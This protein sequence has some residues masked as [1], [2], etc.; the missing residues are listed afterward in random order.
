MGFNDTQRLSHFWI[1]GVNLDY[2]LKLREE[3]NSGAAFG[4]DR[5]RKTGKVRIVIDKHGQSNPV[6]LPE[7]KDGTHDYGR[8]ADL[9]IAWV[10]IL[11]EKA[12][13]R[14][15]E[16]VNREIAQPLANELDA[17]GRF[18]IRASEKAS[19]PFNVELMGRF[20]VTEAQAR[21]L[22][23]A[24]VAAGIIEH[25]HDWKTDETGLIDTCQVCG[26]GRA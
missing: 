15:I 16:Q 14:E 23:S 12:R 22:H 1:D 2:R 18:R 13:L 21:A 8:A 25:E 4:S 6:Q 17:A 19:R 20:D 5:Y 3:M 26:E 7:R 11:R 10:P 9:L 24:L